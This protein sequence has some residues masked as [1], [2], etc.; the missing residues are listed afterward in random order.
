MRQAANAPPAKAIRRSHLNIGLY[1][2]FSLEDI[3]GADPAH[4]PQSKPKAYLS[5][6]AA[7]IYGRLPPQWL[8][9]PPLGGWAFRDKYAIQDQAEDGLDPAELGNAISSDRRDAGR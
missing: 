7:R 1:R 4:G 8:K 5:V 3:F 9:K 2:L 6:F